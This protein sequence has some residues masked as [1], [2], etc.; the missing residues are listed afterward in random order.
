MGNLEEKKM[1]FIFV[2]RK[3]IKTKVSIKVY[4]DIFSSKKLSKVIP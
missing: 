3:S 4:K 1:T 2:S